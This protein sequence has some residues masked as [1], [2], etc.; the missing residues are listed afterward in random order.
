MVVGDFVVRPIHR[1][2]ERAAAAE[3]WWIEWLA[4]DRVRGRR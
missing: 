4:G 1:L 3:R 2:F